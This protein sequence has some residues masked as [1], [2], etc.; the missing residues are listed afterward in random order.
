MRRVFSGCILIFI[1]LILLGA[2]VQ[3][4]RP[5]PVSSPSPTPR[6]CSHELINLAEEVLEDE[7]KR[8]TNI[9]RLKELDPSEEM[10]IAIEL[11]YNDR[12]EKIV[13]EVRNACSQ[14]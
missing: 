10:L 8:E 5:E 14:D 9:K 13:E 3:R 11:M 7:K 12:L 6:A 1:F 2:L 4:Q